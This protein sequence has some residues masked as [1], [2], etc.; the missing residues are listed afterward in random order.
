MGLQWGREVVWI[1]LISS[2]NWACYCFFKIFVFY[3]N[4]LLF[5]L[6][7]FSGYS[8]ADFLYIY[9]SLFCD[10]LNQFRDILKIYMRV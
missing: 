4:K 9:I 5:F 3:L 6:F 2:K 7:Q 1:S 8:L 10:H